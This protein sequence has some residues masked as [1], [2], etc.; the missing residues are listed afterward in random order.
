MPPSRSATPSFALAGAWQ[1]SFG[2]FWEIQTKFIPAYN[3]FG[4]HSYAR[5]AIT[6]FA[7]F[8]LEHKTFSAS[9]FGALVGCA[10]AWQPGVLSRGLLVPLFLLA[11]VFHLVVQNKFYGYHGLPML[12]P[13]AVLQAYAAVAL[14]QK[15]RA[16]VAFRRA[17]A[18]AAVA[19][20]ALVVALNAGAA[21]EPLRVAFGATT[22]RAIWDTARF[23]GY[24]DGGDYSL[25]A[26]LQ[27]AD[28]LRLHSKPSD[29]AFIWGFEPTVYFVAD[30]QCASR[31]IYNFPLYGRVISEG[32]RAQLMQDLR[33]GRPLYIMVVRNDALEHVT[34]TPLDS[35]ASLPSFP[36]LA[37]FIAV[38]YQLEQ[39]IEDFE[40]YRRQAQ[41]RP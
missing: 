25:K 1:G 24:A 22:L 14:W 15:L 3:H 23:G 17:V 11:G 4:G 26:D 16:H 10:L 29:T 33:T 13:A 27:V 37:Q 20:A 21:F 32:L 41:T 19:S 12:A 30:R 6:G 7:R 35:R 31:F 39:T 34:G 28:Y 18:A 9:L 36:E 2:P 40:L 38:N 5:E 8:L